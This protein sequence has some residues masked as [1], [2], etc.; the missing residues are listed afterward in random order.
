MQQSELWMVVVCKLTVGVVVHV[1]GGV[2]LGGQVL[3]GLQQGAGADH[4]RAEEVGGDALAGELAVHAGD[5]LQRVHGLLR[6]GHIPVL[7]GAGAHDQKLLCSRCRQPRLRFLLLHI[8]NMYPLP[9]F[10]YVQPIQVYG[11][12]ETEPYLITCMKKLLL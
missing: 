12:T 5:A 1:L 8:I 4:E 7:Y 9:K 10:H 2:E 11:F 6:C 3:A